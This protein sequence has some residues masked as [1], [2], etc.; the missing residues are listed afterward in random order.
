MP[1]VRMTRTRK[2]SSI[3]GK[4]QDFD[5][6]FTLI[7]AGKAD[8]V[9]D[10][11]RYALERGDA[12]LIPPFRTHVI[13]SEGGEPLVQRIMHFDFFEDPER[14]ALA[15]EDVLDQDRPKVVPERERL[16][17]GR[18]VI[19]RLDD[20][21]LRCC[22]ALYERID[23]E[24]R[25]RLE[26]EGSHALLRAYSTVLLVNMLREQVREPEQIPGE[27]RRS[28]SWLHIENALEYINGHFA[29]E[30]L[31]NEHISRAIGVSPNYLTKRFRTYFG[32]PLHR[33]VI[34]LRVQRAQ[35]MLLS[36][37]CNITETAAAAGFS[38]IHVFSKTFKSVLG[39]SPSVYLEQV[40]DEKAMVRATRDSRVID[41]RRSAVLPEENREQG[42]NST[43]GNEH[44][45]QE[46]RL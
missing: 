19:V 2:D 10:G 22:E 5:H 21:R 26:G 20:D 25:A 11:E 16:L 30:E 14:V 37:R 31:D 40:A 33:Y 24:F 7:T 6:V 17:G 18:V 28:K 42:M 1:F 32:M 29:D 41:R 15:N 13:A 4:W 38:S 8:F 35:Q 39:I 45:Q 34:R 12:I 3:A 9:I 36:G 44:G 43:G 23:A 27:E 46:D